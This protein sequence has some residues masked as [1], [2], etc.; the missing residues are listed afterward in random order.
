M[1]ARPGGVAEHLGLRLAH[2]PPAAATALTAALGWVVIV[3]AMI[4]A[5]GLAIALPASRIGRWDLDA[6]RSL[7]DGRTPWVTD[8]SAAGTLLADTFVV[9]G[10]GATLLA[11][12]AM[13]RLWRPLGIVAVS[14][15]LEVTAYLAIT[16]VISRRRPGVEQLE[17]LRPEASYPS[18]HSAAAFALYFSIAVAIWCLTRHRGARYAAL[19][20]LLCAPIIVALSRMYRG[21]HHPTDVIAGYLMGVGCVLVAIAAVRVG[22]AVSARR[23]GSPDPAEVV[24]PN[25]PMPPPC[26]GGGI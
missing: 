4:G 3:G 23:A 13:K 9:I 5:A 26:V 22:G 8:L 7:E 1:S 17:E 19:A 15:V 25:A 24:S 6:V 20:L 14:L 16:A 10:V 2:L 18:G 21:M 12:L 11:I